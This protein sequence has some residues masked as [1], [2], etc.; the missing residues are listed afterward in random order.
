MKPVGSILWSQKSIQLSLFWVKWVQSA[1]PRPIS[2]IPIW[3]LLSYLCPSFPKVRFIQILQPQP[4]FLITTPDEGDVQQ[5][6]KV[7]LSLVKNIHSHETRGWAPHTVKH[8][9]G[10]GTLVLSRN[11]IQIPHLPRPQ[12][13][14]SRESHPAS[15]KCTN[16]CKKINK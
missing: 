11:R 12:P 7:T 8:I 14:D 4:K 15:W 13:T 9:V 3:I 1:P 2:L 5:S 6:R 16:L 10:G